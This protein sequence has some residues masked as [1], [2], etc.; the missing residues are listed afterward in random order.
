MVIFVKP[1]V[2]EDPMLICDRFLKISS[3]NGVTK[4]DAFRAEPPPL[5]SS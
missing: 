5:S 1:R 2:R 3:V 4:R